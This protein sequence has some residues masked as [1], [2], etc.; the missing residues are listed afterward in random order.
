MK[1]FVVIISQTQETSIE[2]FNG[3]NLLDARKGVNSTTRQSQGACLELPCLLYGV[4]P[5]LPLKSVR[6]GGRKLMS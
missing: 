5:S 4:S 6:A 3:L 2:I 1:V